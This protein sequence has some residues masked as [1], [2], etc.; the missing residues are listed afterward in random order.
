MSYDSPRPLTTLSRRR[1]IQGLA[2]LG[3]GIVLPQSL[4]TAAPLETTSPAELLQRRHGLVRL[5]GSVWGLPLEAE[6]KEKLA[7]L[8]LLKESIVTAEKDLD[9]RTLANRRAWQEAGPAVEALKQALARLSP[10]DPKRIPLQQQLA[11]LEKSF[12]E[13]ARLSCREEIRARL[14]ALSR[15]RSLLQ[16][17]VLW[18]RGNV[19]RLAEEYARLSQVA[20]VGAA[21]QKLGDDRLGPLKQYGVDLKRL[22]EYDKLVFTS[23]LPAYQQAGQTRLTAIVNEQAPV[24]FSWSEQSEAMAYLPTSALEPCGLAAPADASEKTIRLDGRSL[25]VREITIPSLR[26]GKHVVKN[27]PAWV[28]PPEG[29]DLGARLPRAALPGLRVN[30]ELARLRLTIE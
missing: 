10:G 13:P 28:L 5:S 6:L 16:L 17:A 18:I 9:E 21:L 25:S 29:E 24:T 20:E 23:W 15:D 4:C 11:A 8:P 30:I 19:P 22:A 2:V 12:S 7:Q 3:A 26:L 1:A 14:I 27:V